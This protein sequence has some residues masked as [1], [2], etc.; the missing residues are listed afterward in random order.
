MRK[1][2]FLKKIVSIC[3]LASLSLQIGLPGLVS[4]TATEPTGETSL[5]ILT[6]HSSPQAGADWQVLFETTGTADLT[7]TP[8]DQATINDLDFVSLTCDGQPR[9]PQILENDTVFYPNW[10]CGGTAKVIHHVNVA[11]KHTLNFQFGEQIEYAYNSIPNVTF[12]SSLEADI[13]SWEIKEIS[14]TVPSEVVDGNVTV[15][16]TDGTSNNSAFVVESSSTPSTS[17][18]ASTWETSFS[19]TIS[20]NTTWSQDT[21]ITDN[22]TINSGVVL[23]IN[24]GVTVFFAPEKTMDVYGTLTAE[25][26]EANPIYFTSDQ[27]TK[28]AGD[29]GSIKIRLNSTGSSLK[30]CVI[31]YASIAIYFYANSEGS[32]TVAGTFSNCNVTDNSTGIRMNAQARYTAGG[33][34]TTQPTFSN[35]LIKSNTGYGIYIDMSTGY[36]TNQNYAI[37][38][39]NTIRNNDSGIGMSAST[40]WEGHADGDPTIVNN[41]IK[42]NTTYGFYAQS[43]GSSDG[44][45]SDTNFQP[46]LENNVFDNNGTNIHLYLYPYGSDGIQILSPTIRYNTIRNATYGITTVD[47]EAYDT[48]NPTISSNIFYGH[49]SYAINNTTARTITATNNYWG[50]TESAWDSGPQA[51]DTYGTVTTSPYLTTSSAPMLSRIDPAAETAGNSV[52]LYGANFGPSPNTAPSAPTTPYVNESAA[53]AQSGES[54]PTAVG[55]ATPVFSAVYVDTDDGDIADYYQLVV[56]SDSECS[57]EVWDSTKTSMTNCT[58]G[59]RCNDIDFAGAALPFDGKKY[60]WKIK[61]WDDSASEGSYSDCTANFTILGPGDQMR[62]GNYFFNK[63][64]ERVFSW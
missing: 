36:G 8:Q 33:T 58:E 30:Y 37:I 38:K 35:N 64:T 3:L 53:T 34:V 62:H 32:G 45:G 55:D 31:H 48:L 4:A 49:S 16:T 56:Y 2:Y 28:A 25:G 12:P 21:H 59:N 52:V 11:G 19:G 5:K 24:P 39:N 15:T 6:V 51:G 29:W 60:Y 18:E 47:T 50:S 46:V 54:N 27:G 1:R 40:W 63:K 57:S 7:I 23:T 14:A 44:S 17:G 41:T 43:R 9:A 13:S 22:V 61:Y 20:S 42:D 26:T 10:S